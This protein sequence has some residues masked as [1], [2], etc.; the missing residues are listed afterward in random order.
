MKIVATDSATLAQITLGDDVNCE[1]ILAPSAL[2]RESREAQEAP[3]VMADRAFGYGRG[4]AEMSFSWTTERQHADAP[5]A[6]AFAWSHAAAVPITCLLIIT[7]TGFQ[8]RFSLAVITE[9][10][11]VGCDGVRTR[12]AYAVVGAVPELLSVDST[13]PT[14]DSAAT[15]A[16]TD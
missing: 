1:V 2:P 12:I 14:A 9:V 15:T 5:T 3:L 10:A 8:M 11:V 4:N 6:A 13:T 7:E 16:D